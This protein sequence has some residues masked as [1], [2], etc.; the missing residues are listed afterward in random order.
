ME[1]NIFC[2]MNASFLERLSGRALVTPFNELI[3]TSG[4]CVN[5]ARTLPI[6]ARSSI[7]VSS[8][9]ES[10]IDFSFIIVI[11]I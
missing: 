5:S 4:C 6:Y 11:F 9:N 3:L 7:L 2:V 8:L 10:E 1:L